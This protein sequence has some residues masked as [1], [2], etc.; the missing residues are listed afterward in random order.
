V[1]GDPVY[2]SASDPAGRLGLHAWRLALNHPTTGRRL[3]LESPLPAA[4]RRVVG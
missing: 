1:I 4:L 3:E 2:G